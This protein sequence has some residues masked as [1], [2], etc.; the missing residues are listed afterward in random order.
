MGQ[1]TDDSIL[2]MFWFTIWSQK[3][4]LSDSL[5]LHGGVRRSLSAFPFS[6]GTV[7]KVLVIQLLQYE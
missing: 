3:C 6:V 1:G 7:C 4:F 5:S 2:V